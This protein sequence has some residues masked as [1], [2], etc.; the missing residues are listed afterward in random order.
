MP[1]CKHRKSHRVT[2]GNGNF[3]PVPPGFDKNDVNSLFKLF[4]KYGEPQDKHIAQI[5]AEGAGYEYESTFLRKKEK[6]LQQA[7]MLDA[8]MFLKSAVLEHM[9]ETVNKGS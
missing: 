2:G 7:A 3:F 9:R 6:E 8:V 1:R 5:W 4:M